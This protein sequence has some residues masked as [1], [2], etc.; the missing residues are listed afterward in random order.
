MDFEKV[1]NA[2][3]DAIN[4]DDRF[5]VTHNGKNCFWIGDKVNGGLIGSKL[6]HYEFRR[7]NNPD[8]CS[9]EVHFEEADQY[10][11][12]WNLINDLDENRIDGLSLYEVRNKY[13]HIDEGQLTN[14]IKKKHILVREKFPLDDNLYNVQELVVKLMDNL[15]YVDKEIGDRLRQIIDSNFQPNHNVAIPN[16]IETKQ[17]N[18]PLNQILFG[19]PGT[20]K[21]YNTINKAISIINPQ[22][23]LNQERDEVKKEYDRLVKAGQIVFSTFHQNMS[24]EDFIEGIKP[25]TQNGKVEYEV[26]DGIFK[27][28]CVTANTPNQGDFNISYDKLQKK[29]SEVDRLTLSTPTG[30]QFEISLNSNGNLTLYTGSEKKQQGT[31]TKQNIQRQINGED[32]FVGWEGYFKGVI[33]ALEADFGYVKQK[34]EVSEERRKKQKVK[35]KFVLIID[36]INRGNVSSIF[37]EL[38]TLIEDDKRIGRDEAL[39]VTLPYSKKKFGVPDNLYIIG[40]MNTADRS[41][42][43]LDTALRRRFHFEEMAPKPEMLAPNYMFWSLLWKYKKIEWE[44]PDYVKEEKRLLDFIGASQTIWNTRKSIW[45]DF[46]N[47]GKDVKQ[48]DKFPL[49]EFGGVNLHLMLTKINQRIEKLIDKDHRIGHS[50][51]INVQS[52]DDLKEAFRNKVIPL[53]EEYFFGDIGKIGLVLGDS[54]VEKVNGGFEFAAFSGYDS[55]IAQDLKERC[56]YAIKYP[57]D[58]KDSMVWDFKSIYTSNTA[59]K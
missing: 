23:N 52:E 11:R 22:F 14:K 15:Y 6:C 50:Y 3:R 27:Q 42:E 8:T 44:N 33:A 29:L 20:G 35:D 56:V 4:R 39:E 13:V 47:E 32:M 45:K 18:H 46:K 31:L 59:A 51:F 26:Q 16:K 57:K 48:I 41:V 25:I 54:F 17:M 5:Q 43:A 37:G 40:T 53:L 9:I 12:F 49:D 7:N 21:T 55:Q 19:P 38:I 28:I 58:S 2:I 36:E 10:Y 24:Y 30:K 34:V 1:L